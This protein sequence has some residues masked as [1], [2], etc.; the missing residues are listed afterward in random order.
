MDF[1]SAARSNKTSNWKI[2]PCF[3]YC[4]HTDAKDEELA[5]MG[6]EHHTEAAEVEF[7]QQA[8]SVKNFWRQIRAVK[9]LK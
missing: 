9:L 4:Y 6:A 7:I 8:G 1:N 5:Q 2:F 3:L